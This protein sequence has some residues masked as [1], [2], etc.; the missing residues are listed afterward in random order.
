MGERKSAATRVAILAAAA[1][2]IRRDGVATLTLDAVAR[3][4][5]LSKGGLLYHFPSKDA[6]VSAMI[7][8]LMRREDE[9]LAV[10]SDALPGAWLRAY[11]RSGFASNAAFDELSAGLLAAVATNQALLAPV[12]AGF[13][14]WQAR[15]VG[16]G[17][18][19]AI[20]TIVRLAV[21]GLWLTDLLQ[22]AP[23]DSQLRAEV[24]RALVGL[25]HP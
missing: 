18:D 14:A 23:L 13:A 10:A 25:T 2:L 11:V 6:L 9:S 22:I 19:P 24:E 5:N 16:D 4:A 7:E 20:A 1:R 8:E 12:R 15:A 17:V 3:E 21:D